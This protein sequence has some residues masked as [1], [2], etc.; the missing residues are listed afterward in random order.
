VSVQVLRTFLML[1]V[2]P[3]IA[4]WLASR[5]PTPPVT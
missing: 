4:S 1:A 2:A 5:E 3:A